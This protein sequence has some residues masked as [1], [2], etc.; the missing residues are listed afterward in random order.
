MEHSLQGYITANDLTNVKMLLKNDNVMSSSTDFLSYSIKKKHHQMVKLLCLFANINISA[1]K[2]IA[3]ITARN[4]NNDTAL[5]L[6]KRVTESKLF[7]LSVKLPLS[8]ENVTFDVK[9]NSTC[10]K[11]LDF[12]GKF[13]KSNYK[14]YLNQEEILFD[15]NKTIPDLFLNFNPDM[16]DWPETYDLTCKLELSNQVMYPTSGTIDFECFLNDSEKWS[17]GD[18]QAMMHKSDID[19]ID[20]KRKI[21]SCKYDVTCPLLV[22]DETL[23]LDMCRILPYFSD[24]P[25]MMKVLKTCDPGLLVRCAKECITVNKPKSLTDLFSLDT[26]IDDNSNWVTLAIDQTSYKCMTVILSCG[27]YTN[28]H[29]DYGL[30]LA[31]KLEDEVMVDLLTN[32]CNEKSPLI[33][34]SNGSSD[35]G[36]IASYK[37][38]PRSLSVIFHE[39]LGRVSNELTKLDLNDS[40]MSPLLETLNA[41]MR[42][43]L[44]LIENLSTNKRTSVFVN[45]ILFTD[46]HAKLIAIE[47]GDDNMEECSDVSRGVY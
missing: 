21:M 36:S 11:Y 35:N 37:R 17:L 42:S 14:L 44:C 43:I 46:T 47:D 22:T 7:S 40:N 25:N 28:G 23:M 6:M 41:K 34:S 3:E 5:S 8:D 29:V 38:G 24:Y 33:Y 2:K 15:P 32:K 12:M 19:T 9:K 45:P 13:M 1:N 16:L 30:E 20:W 18:Y 31:R 39:L 10:S 27:K 26:W 4:C